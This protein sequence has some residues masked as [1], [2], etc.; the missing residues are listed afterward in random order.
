M[1]ILQAGVTI[2]KYVYLEPRFFLAT[3]LGMADVP[4]LYPTQLDL[5]DIFSL[6]DDFVSF[7]KDLRLVPNKLSVADKL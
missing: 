6:G 4:T 3:L 7:E 5:Q 1:Y 2:C